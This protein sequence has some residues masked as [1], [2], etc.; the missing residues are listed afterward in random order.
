MMPIPYPSILGSSFAGIV[1]EIGP[2]VTRV[3]VGDHVAVN[4]TGK[5]FGISSFAAYQKYSLAAEPSLA[6]LDPSTSFDDASATVVNLATSAAALSITMGLD[7]PPLSGKAESK[8]KKLLVY[9]GS[10]SVGGYAVKYASD[11]GYEVITTSSPGNKDFV[12]RASP[13][14]IIDHTLPH[15]QL[16]SEL[17]SSGPYDAV[18]DTIGTPPVTTLI[19]K[20]LGEKGG[21]YHTT[22][23]PLGPDPVPENVKRNF[24]SYYTLFEAEDNEEMRKWF[25]EKYVPQGLKDG[26]I[27]P[28]R[29]IKKE[30]GLR[31]VQEVLNALLEGV[32]GK[33]FVANPQD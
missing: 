31:C 30:G 16:L 25:Y 21:S 32:S 14:H 11:A 13:S 19:V 23:P 29:Q 15:D 33:K 8:G 18:F 1:E 28:T 17:K 4:K 5:A 12:Q 7:R 24:A 22:Q 26:S 2:S 9:G 6:V 20:L 10:S 27:I 3:K